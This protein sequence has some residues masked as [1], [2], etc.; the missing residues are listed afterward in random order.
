M[1]KIGFIAIRLSIGNELF[2]R[3]YLLY[4]RFD[5]E[6]L[7]DSE[8]AS[9]LHAQRIWSGKS[10]LNYFFSFINVFSWFPL[11]SFIFRQKTIYILSSHPLNIIACIGARLFRTKCVIHIHDPI[12]HSTNKTFFRKFVFLSQLISVWLSNRVIVSGERLKD[13]VVCHYKVPKEKIS[14]CFLGAHRNL[15][16]I[17]SRG[18]SG[19]RQFRV[20]VIGRIEFYKGID[21]FVE[22][23]KYLI[24]NLPDKNIVFTIAGQGDGSWVNHMLSSCSEL[25][26]EFINEFISNDRFDDL[27]RES[28]CVVLPYRDA[29]QTGTVQIANGFGVPCVVTNCGSLPELICKSGVNGLVVEPN[30]RDIALGVS[31]VLGSSASFNSEDIFEY[32]QKQFNWRI[33]AHDFD[34]VIISE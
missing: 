7:I 13:D 20:L 28:R 31:K 11:L 21:L 23:S 2:L 25:R 16:S 27:V 17:V 12:P 32:A 3:N 1:K 10:S 5:P 22:A 29:T 26:F 15:D 19:F 4:S 9:D 14:I 30:A 34:Q 18:A 6:L 8:A 33:R 24:L